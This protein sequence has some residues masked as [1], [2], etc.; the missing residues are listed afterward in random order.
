[1]S[2]HNKLTSAN[3]LIQPGNPV[4]PETIKSWG[5]NL[6]TAWEKTGS[7]Y[8]QPK[9]DGWQ[10]QIHVVRGNVMLFFRRSLKDVTAL[11][12]NIVEAVRIQIDVDSAILDSEVV[13]FDSTE[14]RLLPAT[15]MKKASSHKAFVFDILY[16]NGEDW[17]KIPYNRR[18]AKVTE[19][20]KTDTIDVLEPTK[21]AFVRNLQT[22]KD[23][24]KKYLSEGFEGIIIKNP[25]AIYT[26]GKMTSAK[27]KIKKWEPL[28]VVIL[29]CRLTKDNSKIKQLHVGMKANENTQEFVK[30]GTVD[31]FDD[32]S[33]IN[34]DL[35]MYLL[36][37]LKKIRKGQ[38]SLIDDITFEVEPKFVIEIKS[39]LKRQETKGGRII[40]TLENP[41]FLRLREEKGPEDANTIEN[42]LG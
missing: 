12:P 4:K 18:L 22:L 42:V 1:M 28:D 27:G 17:T 15:S 40:F 2:T 41:Q 26:P 35:N 37:E 21:D 5:D 19:I 39:L 33:A 9:Y 34:P 31:K 29:G 13:P 36:S 32:D 20:I 3:I 16:L 25:N 14:K 23:L 38:Q 30:L 24:Y 10:I 8:V 6:V 11:F 7:C